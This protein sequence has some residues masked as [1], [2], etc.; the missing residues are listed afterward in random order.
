MIPINF[1]AGKIG[2]WGRGFGFVVWDSLGDLMMAGSQQLAGFD[3]FEIAD[4]EACLFGLHHTLS[5]AGYSSL[6]IEGN[7]LSVIS[8]LRNKAHLNSLLGFYISELLSLIASCSYFA[9]NCVKRGGNQMAH[10][11][12]HYQ[13]YLFRFKLWIWIEEIP[14]SL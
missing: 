3:G 2:D 7:L 13:S 14:T 6:V 5:S 1:D 8:K 4:A 10:D 12:A 9:W 11:A